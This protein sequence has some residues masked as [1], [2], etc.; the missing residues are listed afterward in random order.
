MSVEI[1]Q[2]ENAIKV[3]GK[4]LYYT[5]NT[6]STVH[7]YTKLFNREFDLIGKYRENNSDNFVRLEYFT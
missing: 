3:E 5:C 1:V 2:I 6:M 4:K 7:F